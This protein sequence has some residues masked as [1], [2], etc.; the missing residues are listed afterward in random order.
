M[1]LQKSLR[2]SYQCGDVLLGWYKL[3]MFWLDSSCRVRMRPNRDQLVIS[4]CRVLEGSPYTMRW[5][6][7][8][9]RAH[10][11]DVCCLFSG[12]IWV[13]SYGTYVEDTFNLLR[14]MYCFSVY[15]SLF[16][17]PCYHYR[18]KGGIHSGIEMLILNGDGQVQRKGRGEN[19][20]SLTLYC[21]CTASCIAPP[22]ADYNKNDPQLVFGGFFKSCIPCKSPA[23]IFLLTIW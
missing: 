18:E 12:S 9:G 6:M 5:T 10:S 4:D 1:L 15:I 19:A 22:M 7:G 16:Y 14:N 2:L 21:N 23:T 20:G 17:T 11:V 13:D 3:I 8:S